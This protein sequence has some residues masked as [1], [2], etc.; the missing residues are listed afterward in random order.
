MSSPRFGLSIVAVGLLGFSAA[1]I[2]T[3]AETDPAARAHFDAAYGR[4]PLSFEA[5]EGQTDRQVRFLSR[6]SGYTVFLTPTQAVL[7]LAGTP[8]AGGAA[9][10]RP[11]TARPTTGATLGPCPA[12]LPK[13]GEPGQGAAQA[14]AGA[15]LRMS[16][17]GANP[18]PAISGKS[19]LPGKVNYLLGKDPRRWRTGIETYGKVHYSEVYPGI[20]LVYYGNQR[21]LEHDFIV[22]PGADPARIR[23]AFDGARSLSLDPA[24]NLILD[25]GEGRLMWR[26]PVVY[27]PI[28]SS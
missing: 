23:L 10:S 1:A 24:G 14:G 22:A 5:N 11:T 21:Q 7:G 19:P 18:T 15:V 20:D 3:V 12:Q 2:P 16:L 9:P 26:K 8:K 25:T 4:L 27:Q 17:E 13:A 28:E 6:G